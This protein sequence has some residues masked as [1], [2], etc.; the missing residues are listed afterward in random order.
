MDDK[1]WNDMAKGL[2]LSAAYCGAYLVLRYLSFD[3]WFLPAGL[4]AAALLLLP[5]RYWPYIFVGDTAALLTLRAPK[6][7]QYSEMWSYLSPFL[8]IAAISV[9]PR[10]IRNWLKKPELISRWLPLIGLLIAAWSS[11]CNNI[12]NYFLDGPTSLITYQGFA[13]YVIGDY[14]GIL[15]VTVPFLFL[16]RHKN[17]QESP[18]NFVVDAALSVGIIAILFST[19]SLKKWIDPSFQQAL[20]MLMMLPAIG[21]TFLHGWR[22]AAIGI[23]SANLA[24]AQTLTYTGIPGMHDS[25]VFL[26]QLALAIAASTLLLLGEKISHLFEHARQLGI[27]EKQALELA[28]SSFMSN[29][30][31][32]RE[33]VLYMAQMQVCMDDQRKHLVDMLKA[34]EQYSAAMLLNSKAVEHM[35]WFESQSAA[36]YPL[37]IE[38]RGLYAVIH[39][40]SFTDFWAGTAD[41]H[42]AQMRGQPRT[43]TVDLQLAA[44]RCICNAFA[45]LSDCAP[46]AYRVTLRVWRRGGRRGIS[47]K[48]TAT[49]SQPP[50]ISR[51][52]TVAEVDL[53]RRVKAYGGALRRRPAHGVHILLW[54]P[55]DTDPQ[56]QDLPLPAR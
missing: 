7:E 50:Q 31:N 10:I 5:Y 47:I 14:L 24:I 45:L 2:A 16:I 17:C 23:V 29:E 28:Q 30:C 26:P 3:Q 8:L 34:H 11:I 22:G 32:L 4:R 36:L 20:L 53:G 51:A 38:E 6:A 46:D 41:V 1:R 55:A 48:M 25:N 21:L 44:Y 39:P 49:P 18:K 52:S 27:S 56:A 15:M 19:I 54:E 9:A 40:E 37:H 33:K 43:L 42:Y 13:K 12:L 35:Q